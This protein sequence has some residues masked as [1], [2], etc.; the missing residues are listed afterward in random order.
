MGRWG[1]ENETSAGAVVLHDLRCCLEIAP[2]MIGLVFETNDATLCPVATSNQSLESGILGT[3]YGACLKKK[4][5]Q[6]DSGC[7][8][9]LHDFSFIDKDKER[10]KSKKLLSGQNTIAISCQ[11]SNA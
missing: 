7:M 3:V 5:N 10:M 6:P 2:V 9:K 1:T 4:Q 8:Y 11:R